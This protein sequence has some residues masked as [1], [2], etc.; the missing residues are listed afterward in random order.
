M[1]MENKN[2][3]RINIPINWYVLE[4]YFQSLQERMYIQKCLLSFSKISIFN[5]S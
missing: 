4:H 2:L 5:C 1:K 3:L